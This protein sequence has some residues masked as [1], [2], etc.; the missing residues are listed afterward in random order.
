M[1][2]QNRSDKYIWSPHDAYFYKGLSEL[3]VDIDRL[4]YLSLEKIR[5]DFVFINLNTD[6]LTEFIN[7]DNEWLSA[8]KGKQVVLIAARKSEALANYWYYNS[9]IRGVVYAGLSR[10]IRKELAYVINGRFLRKDIKADYYQS[11]YSGTFGSLGL[12][13]GIQRYNNGDSSANTGK[14]IALDLSLPL[15]NWFSAGMTHQNGYTMANLSARKQFDEGTIR[16]VGANLSRAISGDTGDDK[17]LS[18][19]AYAQFDARYASGTL[20]VN[21]AADGYIN[22]NLT[23]NGSI[24][25]QGKNIAASG[26][27]DGNA[28]VIFDTGL[29]NDGQISAKINGRIFPLNGK[30]NYLPLSPYGRYEV[31]L[32]N[33]KNSLDSYDIVSGRKSHLTLYP[34]NVAVIEPEVKQMVTVSGR[35]RA[36]DGTLL[37]NARINNHIGRT[38]TDENGEFVMDVDKKY[39]TID[40]RYSGNKTCEVALELN[41]ARGAVWVGDVVCSGLSSWAAVTQTG[42]ENES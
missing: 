1:E 5:K 28:G 20:N 8:V 16:T 37:A 40:F 33:S 23:A 19:G 34:G 24:G 18:G 17:T 11:V 35:I 36:E 15:G 9:N 26:R 30:R 42:E 32:Q 2:C 27:T 7:R 12:R 29:E 4:I 3:I 39:P 38:R 13:A 25:W 22:T 14:Y 6:S 21:S 41:Q 10:D 31:E